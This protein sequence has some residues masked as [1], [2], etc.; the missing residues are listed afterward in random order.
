MK[1]RNLLILGRARSALIPLESPN[2]RF[3]GTPM[4]HKHFGMKMFSAQ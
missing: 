2:P 3:C 4:A 1:R